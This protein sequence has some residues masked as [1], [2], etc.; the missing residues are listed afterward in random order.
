MKSI[1]FILLAIISATWGLDLATSSFPPDSHILWIVRQEG[2]YLTGLL[3]IALMSLSMVLAT[4]PAWLEKPL[5]GLDRIYRLHKWSGILAIGFG[6][7]HWLLKLS[8]DILK[9][10]I[11]VE[12]RLPKIKYDGLLEVLRELGDDMGE[13]ALYAML[14]MLAVTLWRRFPYHLWRHLHR[15]MPV[16]YLMLA[17]HA[18]LLAPLT[19]WAQP[20][21]MLMAACLAVG[22]V[23]SVMSLAGMIGRRRQVN[24]LVVA[25]NSDGDV[26]EVTCQLDEQWQAHRPGQFA[27]ITFDWIEGAHPFTIASADRG[28]RTITF[29]IKA[30]GDFTNKLAQ[31]V[32]TGQT[33]RI[34]G[35]YG[36]FQ[37]A[38]SKPD[39]RQIWVAGGI[40][41][42]PFLAWLES[43]QARPE[44]TR[45]A[46]LH[47]CT[48][49]HESDPF[50]GRLQTLCA[51]LPGIRL[52]I[53]SAKHGDVLTADALKLAEGQK[54][55]ADVWFCGPSGLADA[56]KKGLK[57]SWN[58]RLRFHQEA[59]E[60]R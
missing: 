45:E 22:V 35:P 24:G 48:R 36:R 34:E 21:G 20:V 25:V 7:S 28:E 1:L 19:Y 51:A 58:G 38:R 23:A 2:M 40:G 43:L 8:S 46:D 56:L 54:K 14:A 13:P 52:N 26:T 16:L 5:G 27:F 55:K 60:M 42:T 4:R 18:A 33:V 50:V 10:L 15:V 30:L 41:V 6:A 32:K 17:L 9:P 59:F 39:S 57:D 44:E 31:R 3:S 11:G 49:N 53:H 37:L 47:Y 12:G 29:F